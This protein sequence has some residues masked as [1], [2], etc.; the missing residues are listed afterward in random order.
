MDDKADTIFIVSAHQIN[1][2]FAYWSVLSMLTSPA[3]ADDDPT[4]SSDAF[5][6]RHWQ[7]P[8]QHQGEPPASFSALEISLDP[9]ACGSCHPQ[10]FQ[11]WQ[12]SLHAHAMG[13]GL[14]GQLMDMNPS[15]RAEHQ[16]CLHCH[17]PLAEQA[18]ELVTLLSPGEPADGN[19]VE[20]NIPK[21]PPYNQ[22]LICA[23]CH[24]RNFQVYGPQRNKT[25]P[26]LDED[27]HLPHNGW[28]SE[29][30]FENSQF[31][32]ACHQFEPDGYA[33]NGKLLENTFKEWQASPQ[34]KE[35][36]SCQSCHMPGR[37]HL[38]RGIHDKATVQSGV[39]IA[40]DRI[41][42]THKGI[43]GTLTLTNTDTGHRF[44]TYV[45]P[46]VVM[47][48]VQLDKAEN[49]IPETRREQIIARQVTL[50]LSQEL[51]DT[52]LA[53]GETA[54]LEY[55]APMH[56]Q[57]GSIL[58][59]I[60]VEPDTFYRDFYRAILDSD[61]SDKGAETLRLALRNAEAS[62][63]TLFRRKVLLARNNEP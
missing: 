54:R 46:R 62:V 61:S 57:A 16:A 47:E 55:Q 49:P 14:L 11:D 2:L 43:N 52:R 10:Q 4:N 12:G 39:E 23:A 24:L 44:P 33:L 48:A 18:D 20:D 41:V 53:P 34:A 21:G 3:M 13:P 56:P 22:G 31:C 60:Q 1:F 27:I 59:R 36:K 40:V 7:R 26:P 35:G 51:F 37:R 15:D 6:S 63:Y 17:A 28:K 50:D 32:A 5:L 8:L 30:A 29:D 42:I 58:F 45:T 9:R 25:L 19:P 38:W